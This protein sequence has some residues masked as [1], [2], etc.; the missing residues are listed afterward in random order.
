MKQKL[1]TEA[2][3]TARP[4]GKEESWDIH[5]GIEVLDYVGAQPIE[6]YASM[7]RERCWYCFIP[8]KYEGEYAELCISRMNTD[9]LFVV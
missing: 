4:I 8:Y 7:S 3:I 6:Y 2:D 9:L 1:Q 5:C